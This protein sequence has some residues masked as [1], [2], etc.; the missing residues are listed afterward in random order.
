M[1]DQLGLPR[2]KVVECI[3]LARLREDVQSAINKND[4]SSRELL[5]EIVALKD[6]DKQIDFISKHTT[7]TLQDRHKP[8]LV[9]SVKGSPSIVRISLHNYG[10]N[11][12]KKG[13]SRMSPEHKKELKTLLTDLIA[14][15]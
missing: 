10:F 3:N 5:R 1:A 12:Q 15:L 4:I 14:E 13:L 6:A 2:T 7:N 11:V 9:E 8:K